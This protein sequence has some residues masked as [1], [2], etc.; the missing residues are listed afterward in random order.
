MDKAAAIRGS[1]E[2]RVRACRKKDTRKIERNRVLS[3]EN[4]AGWIYGPWRFQRAGMRNHVRNL[5][6]FE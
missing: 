3:A 4:Y 5:R 1:S 2:F 6:G